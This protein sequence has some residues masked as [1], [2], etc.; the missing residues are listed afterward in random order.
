MGAAAIPGVAWALLGRDGAGDDD[1]ETGLADWPD[2]APTGITAGQRAPNFRLAELDGATR[3]LDET[4]LAAGGPIVL[5]FF[6]TWCVSCREEMPVLDAAHGTTATVVGIDLRE[7]ADHVR[8]LVAETGIRYP[9]LLDRDGS[10]T[11]A[12]GASGLPTNV[13]LESDGTVRQ[14]I[15]GPVTAGSL[16]AAL[17]G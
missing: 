17:G 12:Y 13:I 16:A 9:V 14:V 8:P 11:R 10:V 7:D 3:T 2:R 15:I 5:N 1:G 4:A 6:A